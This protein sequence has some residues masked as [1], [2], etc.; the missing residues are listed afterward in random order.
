M[1]EVIVIELSREDELALI[2][3]K[4]SPAFQLLKGLI[5]QEKINPIDKR[6]KGDSGKPFSDIV[7]VR[8]LQSERRGLKA[9]FSYLDTLTKEKPKNKKIEKDV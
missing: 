1:K 5:E 6:L 3:L 8:E 9:V 4:N 2:H 7:E